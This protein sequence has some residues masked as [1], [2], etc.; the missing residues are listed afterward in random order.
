MRVHVEK[1]VGIV[2][3]K[4]NVH[5]EYGVLGTHYNNIWIGTAAITIRA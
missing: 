1:R 3:V 5:N 4:H 2:V